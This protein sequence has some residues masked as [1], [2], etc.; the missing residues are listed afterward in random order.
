MYT[1]RTLACHQLL[2]VL[3]TLLTC[4]L[5][6][7]PHVSISPSLTFSFCHLPASSACLQT[8]PLFECLVQHPQYYGPQLDSMKQR[9]AQPGAKEQRQQQAP[10]E[11]AAGGSVGQQAPAAAGAAGKLGAA[12]V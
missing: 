8:A 3:H 2:L 6:C 9:N 12:A 5:C 7:Q 1:V 10:A 4:A 11:A